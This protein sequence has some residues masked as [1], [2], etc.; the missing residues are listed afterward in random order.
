[1]SGDA[2]DRRAKAGPIFVVGSM[3]S[4]STMLRLILD[5]H[6]NIAVGEETGFMGGLL[7]MKSIPNWRHGDQWYRRL[8]WTEDEVDARLRDFYGGMFERHAFGQGKVRWGE[9]TPFHTAHMPAM[10]QVFPDAVFVGIVRHPGAVAVSLRKS[11]HY[12]FEQAL[13]YWQAT[14]IEM[15]NAATRLGPRFVACR[16]E[17]LVADAEPVLRELV[18]YLDEPW[19][20]ALLEHHRVQQDKGA[21]RASDGST[22]TRDPLD[23][24]RAESWSSTATP[25]DYAALEATAPLAGF[26]GYE[27]ASA[28]TREQFAPSGS[29]RSSLPTGDDLRH[30]RSAWESRVS[31]EV[32]APALPLD[33]RPEEL[34][35]RVA[36]LEEV[37]GRVRSRK[38]VRLSDALRKVQ[39]GRSLADLREVWSVLRDP[40]G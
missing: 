30:R 10:A 11:F 6:P 2:I 5:S 4:G 35:E 26:F 28:L 38:A 37:L 1:V 3:R 18:E 13:S 34:A 27:S 39:H 16:Y 7:A 19:S 21:P 29:A 20:D 9:K 31:F 12:T 40:T 8:S 24:R 36:H 22:I 25:A 17:D 15:V 33:A 32:T 23:A 14:N